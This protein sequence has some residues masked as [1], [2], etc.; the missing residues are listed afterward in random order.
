MIKIR[1]WW[2]SLGITVKYIITITLIV[3]P[4]VIGAVYTSSKND[5]MNYYGVSFNIVQAE[6]MRTFLVSS[7]VQQIY[8]GNEEGDAFLVNSATALLEEQLPIY[9]SH[10]EAL[11]DGDTQLGIKAADNSRII[12]QLEIITPLIEDYIEA[13]QNVIDD[14]TDTVSR[15]YVIDNTL[16]IDSTL[17]QLTI[18][19]ENI[20]LSSYDQLSSLSVMTILVT[21]FI[22]GFSLFLLKVL[23]KNEYYAKYD[24]LTKVRSRSL[25]FDD[26]LKLKA[27]D[28]TVFYF[29]IKNFKQINEIYGNNIGDDILVEFARRLKEICKSE[30]VYRFAGDEFVIFTDDDELTEYYMNNIET[31]KEQLL[32]PFIDNK[33]REHILSVSMGVVT[34][35][36]GITDFEK[37]I[38]LAIDLRYDSAN[39]KLKPMICDT[40]EKTESRIE[41]KSAI[42]TAIEDNQIIAYFQPL[43]TKEGTLK[44]FESLARWHFKDKVISPGVFLPLINR[45]GMGFELDM[46]MIE[47][48]AREFNRLQEIKQDLSPYVSINLTIDTINNVKIADL[49]ARLDN[50][51]TMHG[52]II[53]EILEDVVIGSKTR[54]KLAELKK[55]GYKIALDDFT[56]G[57]TSFEYL[58][59]P[60][61]DYVKID[62]QVLKKLEEGKSKVML[63]DLINM[64]HT[65]DK[66]VIIEGIETKEELDI[67][68]ELGVDVIQ[69]YYYSKPLPIKQ[70]LEFL[71]K[72]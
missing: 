69:G 55:A 32:M 24:I 59:I 11:I 27:D 18:L 42:H 4:F 26:I 60:E 64:I 70:A 16:I 68:T 5:D 38:N 62:K 47:S 71:E 63:H 3:I 33:G 39:Y 72:L 35:N 8:N 52:N 37:K 28:F 43:F 12:A 41:I 54:S 58:K 21:V 15:D 48:V 13:A 34:R 2:M 65:S 46:Q 17:Y 44:G 40:L 45:N 23:R 19:Y 25:I 51:T 31:L 7:Y 9:E 6:R 53:L 56:T 20:Y 10:F 14:P 29:D 67:V 57:A 36:V 50:I 30:Y 1:D 22:L 66:Q 61:I 49:I